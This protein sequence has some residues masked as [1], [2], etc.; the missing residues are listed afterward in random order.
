MNK[1]LSH[2]ALPPSGS[3]TNGHLRAEWHHRWI[4]LRRLECLM[5]RNKLVR[6][7]FEYRKALLNFRK[8]LFGIRYFLFCLVFEY[9]MI[10]LEFRMRRFEGLGL[11][12]NLNQ[13]V[14]DARGLWRGR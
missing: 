11:F 14:A 6:L 5:L 2:V 7:S 1:R 4:A 3:R 12:S 8:R 9:R 13:F 10:V